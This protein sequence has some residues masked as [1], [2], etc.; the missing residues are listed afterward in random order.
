MPIF[1]ILSSALASIWANKMRALLT[2]F[3]IIVGISSVVLIT[4]VGNGLTNTITDQFEDLGLDELHIFHTNNVRPVEW[5]ER[6]TRDDAAFL[7]D[8]PALG[9]VTSFHTVMYQEAIDVLGTSDRRA[10][11]L[12]GVEEYD[13]FLGGR[14]LVYGRFIAAA[15]VVNEARVI[16]IDETF[17]NAVFGVTNSI[18]RELEI[19]TGE[20]T[21][22]F[23]VIGILQS[24]E[25]F[26]FAQMFE[27]PF[28][29]NVPITVTQR[30]T[31]VGNVV[32]QITARVDDRNNIHEIGDNVLRILEIRKGATDIYDVFGMATILTEVNN[33]V[34]VFTAFLAL[35][36][37]ISLLVGGIGVM[38]IMLVSVTERTR[39]IGIR[40]SLG[41]TN[42]NISFQFLLEAACLTILG[43]TIGIIL[44]YLGGIGVGV[45]AEAV[46]N[47]PLTP[48]LNPV[49]VAAIVA[50][51]GGI[52][53][54]FGVYPAIKASRL[55]PVESLRFE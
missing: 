7:R 52:G 28:T 12:I 18:G 39:E 31:N 19:R 26:E 6:L 25:E 36:A 47:L 17:S 48:S 3:G 29:A 16:L 53:I 54:L 50:A 10:V 32:A 8:H 37:M 23:S 55:D 44:G 1:E 9:V 13:Q 35:V 22:R 11:Q 14:H 38:N 27:M 33:I 46:L 24:E 45:L 2:M 15:D 41:A 34:G 51:S 49:V 30:L 21:Q 40:K 5:H 43:G 20:G 42:F 4:G